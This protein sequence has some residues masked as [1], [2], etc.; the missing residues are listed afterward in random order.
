MT[1]HVSPNNTLP[2]TEQTPQEQNLKSTNPINKLAETIAGIASQQRAQTSSALFKPT[3][4]N[5]LIFDGKNDKFELFEDLFET[6][7]GKQPE[8]TEAMKI[9]QFHS[10]LRKYALQTFRNKIASNKGFSEDVLIIFLRK[11]VR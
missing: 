9:I 4:T 7:L 11:Y 2:M 8:M 6:M 10:H 1:T 5:T 3:T